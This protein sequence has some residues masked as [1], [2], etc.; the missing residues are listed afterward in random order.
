MGETGVYCTCSSKFPGPPSSKSF[1]GHL[2][3][4]S[5]PPFVRR[6]APCS[7][8]SGGAAGGVRAIDTA[9]LRVPLSPRARPHAREA[10]PKGRPGWETRADRRW[11]GGAQQ[12]D[13]HSVP[14]PSPAS[15]L[16]QEG[17]AF[18]TI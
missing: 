14:L 10:W 15:L 13:L 4:T 12:S 6:R 16:P 9:R 1:H 3:P 8:A 17:H 11:R 18:D 7:H 5:S 2:Q